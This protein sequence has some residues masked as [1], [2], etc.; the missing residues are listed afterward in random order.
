MGCGPWRCTCYS[1]SDSPKPS[2]VVLGRASNLSAPFSSS[3]VR[4]KPD[5][6]LEDLSIVP[7][8]KQ[9]VLSEKGFWGFPGDTVLGLDAFTA[10]V[11][12][13]PGREHTSHKSN[14]AQPHPPSKKKNRKGLSCS[15][16]QPFLQGVVPTARFPDPGA[17]R[18][19]RRGE[20]RQATGS[21]RH[22]ME[23]GK[24]LAHP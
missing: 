10:G 21:R 11:G 24:H 17:S 18:D 9:N 6:Q 22:G 4:L 12:S 15:S 16:L 20:R 19:G 7:F 1:K 2:C 5:T 8:W 14:G 13:V 3:I 23:T